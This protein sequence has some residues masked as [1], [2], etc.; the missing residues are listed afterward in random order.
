MEFVTTTSIKENSC[1]LSEIKQDNR[2]PLF[3]RGMNDIIWGNLDKCNINTI[4]ALFDEVV[5]SLPYE[6]AVIT[7][8]GLIKPLPKPEITFVGDYAFYEKDKIDSYEEEK[9]S[10]TY[11]GWKRST[12]LKVL[13]K[14]LKPTNGK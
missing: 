7:V 9:Y 10:V 5:L 11:L 4:L 14:F 2:T 8:D 13:I 1:I 3:L 12:S 6:A